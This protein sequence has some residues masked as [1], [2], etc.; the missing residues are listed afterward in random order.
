MERNTEITDLR[1]NLEAQ[2][3]L[4]SRIC[5]IAGAP[6]LSVSVLHLGAEVYSHHFGH[7]SVKDGK[8]PDGDTIYFIGSMTKAMVSAL[9]GTLDWKAPV[10]H[11]L[12]ELAHAFDGRGCEITLIDLLSHKIGVA[13]ADALWLQ[14]AGDIL[15][16]KSEALDAS[17]SQQFELSVPTFFIPILHSRLLGELLMDR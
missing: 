11:I 3:D 16:S 2:E 5:R 15:L 9:D 13:R 1:C 6:G 4:I 10:S 14:C 8:L 7:A 12:P 17:L